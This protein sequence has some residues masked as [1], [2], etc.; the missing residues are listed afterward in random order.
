MRS[1]ILVP[2]AVASALLLTTGCKFETRSQDFECDA[3]TDCPDDRVCQNGLCVQVVDTTDAAVVDGPI[4]VPDAGVGVDGAPPDAAPPDCPAAC[5]SCAG[6]VCTI[7]CELGDCNTGVTCPTGWDCQV[8][9]NGN[10]TC[11]G[12]VDCTDATSCDISCSGDGSCSGAITCGTG[13]CAVGC[14]GAAT[15]QGGIDCSNSCACD[16]DCSGANACSMAPMCQPGNPCTMGNGD[17]QSGQGP[18]DT[19]P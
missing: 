7:Q 13:R 6:T 10:G 15:C 5:T 14:T 4:G 3:P 18:C 16:T 12:A 9:C 1:L 2:L 19:C 17:C 8:M 11:A